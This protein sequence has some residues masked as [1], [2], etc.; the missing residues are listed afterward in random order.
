MRESGILGV[1]FSELT[2]PEAWWLVFGRFAGGGWSLAIAFESY[3]SCLCQ[4]FVCSGTA[5][6]GL[7]FFLWLLFEEA[8]RFD[9]RSPPSD[10]SRKRF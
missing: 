5:E 4:P 3:R 9:F 8:G 10:C 6:E 2:E 7:V 1:P